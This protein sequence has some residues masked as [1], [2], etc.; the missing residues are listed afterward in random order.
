MSAADDN[1]SKNARANLFTT[2]WFRLGWSRHVPATGLAILQPL[3]LHGPLSVDELGRHLIPSPQ[4][5]DLG[6]ESTAWEPLEVYT[7][8]SLQALRAEFEDTPFA[9]GPDEPD[10]A[11]GVMAEEARLR[12][13]RVDEIDRWSSELG[14]EPVR[15]LRHLLEFLLA[16]GVLTTAGTGEA[17]L[18]Q[19]SETAPLPGE[20]LSLSDEDRRF[21]DE[22]RWQELH[23]PAAQALIDL[24]VPG[25]T[26]TTT[27]ATSLQ[28]L[29]RQLDLTVESVRAGVLNL[30]ND[31]DFT[32]SVDVER[33]VEHQVFELTVD[34]EKFRSSRIT[35][36]HGSDD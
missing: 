15:T 7:D 29:A 18:I 25:E 16:A 34:W 5:P 13:E 24:F 30:L 10:T 17:A 21:D 28:R 12:Q 23:E 11:E 9:T 27:L 36:V 19:L 1:S 14:V 33:L 35:V 4:A 20:V 8:E 26:A 31:G 2:T 22:M 32:A 3:I 6:W